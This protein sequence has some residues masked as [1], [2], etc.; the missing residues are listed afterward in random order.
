MLDE[1]TGP[2]RCPLGPAPKPPESDFPV[3]PSHHP[4]RLRR[5]LL[6]VTAA[7]AVA[8]VAG[9]ALPAGSSSTGTTSAT[10]S[11][12]TARA[13]RPTE[14]VSDGTRS[15]TVSQAQN[16]DPNGQ[17]VQISG[18][19]YD[20]NKG[21][22]VAFCVEPLPGQIPTPCGGGADTEGSTGASFWISSNPPSYG[23]GLAIPYGPGGTFTQ[24]I[25]VSP[26]IGNVDCRRVQC[27]IASRNDHIRTSDRGQ[28][29][30]VPI[31]FAAPPADTVP[32]TTPV[33]PGDGGTQ[34]ADTTPTTAAPTTTTRPT[35]P[36]DEERA[37]PT[38]TVAADGR[39]VSA[40]TLKLTS[41]AVADL[42]P[43]GEAVIV[44]GSGFDETKGVRI[45]F[46]ATPTGATPGP[47]L[48]AAAAKAIEADALGDVDIS[49]NPSE[50]AAAT[51]TAYGPSGSFG[52]KLAVRAQIDDAT[53]C[54]KVAC[55]VV[56]LPHPDR[57]KDQGQDLVLP[58]TF[59]QPA[60][61]T[62]TAAPTTTA[63]TTTT[64]P[65]SD[66]ADGD[67]G[68]SNGALLGGLAA[69][70]IAAVGGGLWW[71]RRRKAGAA[72]GAA[73]TATAADAPTDPTDPTDA[74]TDPSGDGGPAD[75]DA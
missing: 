26:M 9:P 59:E 20:V 43:D 60:A 75:G 22:Y 7:L 12:R 64:T 35:P 39:S 23:E 46:C 73:T 11:D 1:K 66:D 6:A 28:D 63:A 68:G 50:A 41:T 55:G 8:T 56:T 2:D 57:P 17:A 65:A 24:T 37:A 13:A 25:N 74:P 21:I 18:S 31:S 48:D 29:L 32:D 62:T 5:G 14:S 69:L 19:G 16:L 70:V 33:D 34:P 45:A 42:D 72:A 52:F 47:C 67:T 71:A 61:T 38:G 10:T 3:P 44:A 30:F 27:V 36:A 54:R 51:S 49:S 40:G 15:L 53:D 4:R 58:V